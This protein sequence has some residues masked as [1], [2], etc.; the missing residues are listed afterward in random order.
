MASLTSL[1]PRG[2]LRGLAPR[3]RTIVREHRRRLLRDLT[4]RV[5]DLGGDEDHRPLYPVSTE[6]VAGDGEGPFDHVVSILHL[7]ASPDPAAELAHVRRV[8]RPGGTFVFLEPAADTGLGGRSQRLV[9]P[10]A[11]RL[12]GWRPD[13][14]VPALLRDAG[15]VTSDVQRTPLPRYAWPLTDLVEGRALHRVGER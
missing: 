2:Y 4:G 9:S 1:V 8:L 3:V 12:G 7:A 14:D 6:V 13:L 11:Q 15:F 10:V 5:L